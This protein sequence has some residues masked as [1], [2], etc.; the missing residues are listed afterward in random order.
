MPKILNDCDAFFA[1]C[2]QARNPRLKGKKVL[3]TGD[4]ERRSVITAA[5]YEAR[6]DGVKAGTPIQEAR[7]LV[8]DGIFLVGDLRLYLDFNLKLFKKLRSYK[9]PVEIYSIDEFYL[10]FNGTYQEAATLARDFKD[11][12]ERELKITVSIGIAPTKVFAKLASE[13]KKPNGLAML[14]PE[15]IPAKIENLPVK[16]VFGVGPR[17]EEFLRLRAVRTIGEL[18]AY[19][20]LTLQAELGVRGKWLH[21][22]VMG[23][24]DDI[25]K[26]TPDPYKSMGHELTLPENTDDPDKIRAFLYFL[27]D[28]VGQRLRADGSLA[29]TVHLHLRYED[30]SGFSRSKTMPRPF[31]LTEDILSG[32]EYLLKKEKRDPK[33]LIRLLGIGASNLKPACGYQLPLFPREQKA[34][35]L[36]SALDKIRETYGQNSI[37]RASTLAVAGERPAIGKN[38]P[39][40]V[41]PGSGR[42]PRE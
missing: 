32:A 13:L 18:R 20:P 15:D 21:D 29:R 6:A 8:P 7:R 28:S 3:V 17:T 40:A 10:D 23:R 5:S 4:T 16:E 39:F 26:V 30:F 34:L 35:A 25:V 9:R 33:R 11:W 38:G 2:E 24:N 14:K 22:A 31:C 37:G 12:V 36:A 27:A 41:V 1:S 42:G 19:N